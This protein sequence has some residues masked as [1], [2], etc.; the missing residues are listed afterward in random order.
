MI[1]SKYSKLPLELI[2]HILLYTGIVKYRNGKYIDQIPR[3]DERYQIFDSIPRYN[4][5]HIENNYIMYVLLKLTSNHS[6]YISVKFDFENNQIEY[7]YL[8]LLDTNTD[9]RQ[10]VKY[11]C[12]IYITE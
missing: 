8:H 4:V 2:Y 5:C 10:Y 9:I 6:K 7:I 11:T 1:Y 12:P 3:T